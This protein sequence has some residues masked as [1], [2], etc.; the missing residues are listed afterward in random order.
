M[1]PVNSVF[2]PEW[3]DSLKEK[4]AVETQQSSATLIYSSGGT[5]RKGL[6]IFPYNIQLVSQTDKASSFPFR[7]IWSYKSSPMVR[8]LRLPMV[9]F[10][11]SSSLMADPQEGL[12][13]HLTFDESAG[14]S[15]IHDTSGKNRH[16]QT[17]ES[18]DADGT[19]L[20][21]TVQVAPGGRYRFLTQGYLST[22][23]VEASLLT[24]GEGETPL[25]AGT[26]FEVV[27]GSIRLLRS[28]IPPNSRLRYTYYYEN[29]P[30]AHEQGVHGN[31]LGFDGVNDWVDVTLSEPID[32]SSGLTIS[33]WILPDKRRA[34]IEL[35]FK[36]EG[37]CGISFYENTL[38]FL[39]SGAFQGS[40]PKGDRVNF[41][42]FTRPTGEWTHIA[43]VT[44]GTDVRLYV[45][46][47]ETDIASGVL[48][49]PRQNAPQTTSIR[50][51]GGMSYNYKGLIDD[52]RVYSR[53]LCAEEIST[54]ASPAK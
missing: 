24:K 20:T 30:L 41:K 4:L 34:P 8:Y 40:D 48:I 9:A 27:G 7:E 43:I 5:T 15:E 31:A 1:N 6:V 51:G 38:A 3:E 39:Y 33:A 45:N 36:M 25:A 10:I 13:L 35:L 11:A 16:G 50:I 46:G 23:P 29:A 14:T 47:K 54:L 18:K 53:P 32:L 12:E 21:Q 22:R 28:D 49:G 37:G 52:L 44:N 26:D 42:N 19:P 17:N 2:Q